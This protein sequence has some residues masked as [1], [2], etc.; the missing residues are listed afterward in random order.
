ME[1][2]EVEVEE[3]HHTFDPVREVRGTLVLSHLSFVELLSRC[4]LKLSVITYY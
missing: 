4:R 3:A 2:E 1:E